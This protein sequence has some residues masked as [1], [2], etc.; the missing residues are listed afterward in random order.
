MILHIEKIGS[1]I[2]SVDKN[3]AKVSI[4]KNTQKRS[5]SRLKL[6]NREKLRL[7][8]LK[9]RH[10]SFSNGGLRI[11]EIKEKQKEMKRRLKKY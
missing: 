5:I 3:F 1:H 8:R 10:R 11:D 7:Q 9:D 6:I 2:S 4:E